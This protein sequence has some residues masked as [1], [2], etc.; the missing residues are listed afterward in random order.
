[1][2]TRNQGIVGGNVIVAYLLVA[3]SGGFI[4]FLLGFLCGWAVAWG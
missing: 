2:G 3:L 4:G 1:M